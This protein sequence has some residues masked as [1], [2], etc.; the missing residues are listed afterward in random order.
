MKKIYLHSLFLCTLFAAILTAC[1][2]DESGI[3][4]APGIEIPQIGENGATEIYRTGAVLNAKVEN[5]NSRSI[6]ESGFIV[7]TD[8]DFENLSMD[9]IRSSQ[10]CKIVKTRKPVSDGNMEAL[11]EGLQLDRK[12]YFCAYA[13][14]GYS[15][16]RSATSSFVTRKPDAP[17]ITKPEVDDITMQACNVA[18][19][20]LDIGGA[21]D[22]NVMETHLYFKEVAEGET[23]ADLDTKD[24]DVLVPKDVNN[25]TV[26][27]FVKGTRY[28]VWVKLYTDK[29]RNGYSRVEY[30]TTANY[31]VSFENYTAEKTATGVTV[32]ATIV[33]PEYIDGKGVMY[34]RETPE[35]NEYNLVVTDEATPGNDINVTF[36]PEHKGLHYVRPYVRIIKEGKQ[37]YIY[38]DVIPVGVGV[39]ELQP[40]S[41]NPGSDV[42]YSS[43]KVT[44]KVVADGGETP[45]EYGFCYIASNG[46]LTKDSPL[47]NDLNNFDGIIR[48]PLSKVQSDQTF[49][50]VITGLSPQ[51]LYFIRAYSTNSNGMKFSDILEVTTAEYTGGG[52]GPNEGDI[53]LPDFKE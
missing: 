18:F 37:I 34:S 22:E 14:S 41:Y 45:T 2:E 48:V 49:S 10:N 27:R 13:S 33:T 21:D 36:E 11:V 43:V 40:I 31:D 52:P 26:A 30:F 28:A 3:H 6:V 53:D 24:F 15:V 35:P 51:T 38:G 9:V 19:K 29:G 44:S 47:L 20:V 50:T 25:M 12:Y 42:T 1:S 8:Q 5:P 7:S 46:S 4:M 16:V 32:K 17:V 39:P 23:V